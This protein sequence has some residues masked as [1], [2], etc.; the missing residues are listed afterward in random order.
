MLPPQPVVPSAPWLW[1]EGAP[2]AA[3]P[4]P[5]PEETAVALTYGR[6]TYAVMM[7]T[8][9]DLEDFAVGFSL[10]EGIV[11]AADE[12]A[13]LEVLARPLGIELRM[14]LP[15]ARETALIARRRH[16]L[17]AT[18]CGL[19]GMESLEAA[20]APPPKVTA[21][22]PVPALALSQAMAAMASAQ[23]LN[24]ETHAV[25]AACFWDPASGAMVLREDVGRHNALDKLAGAMARAGTPPAS[26]VLLLTSRVS[27]E[28]VQKAA[29]MGVGVVAAVSVPTA[30]AVRVAETAGITLI[31]VARA[32]G[33]EIFAH[34]ER[35]TARVTEHVA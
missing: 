23:R 27:V 6:A 17:G 19:C 28:L 9:D 8:P 1:R 2:L 26:G 15:P 12:I 14:D 5:L 34:P 29:V 24:R 21:A 35:I 3:R 30:L 10:N 4:R 22:L 31:A 32:D 33:F 13:A 20:T 7:A 16:V 18:G 25:H 11:T